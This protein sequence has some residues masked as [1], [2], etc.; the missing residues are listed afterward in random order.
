[1]FLRVDFAKGNTKR[2][3]ILFVMDL[4]AH[5]SN[6]LFFFQEGV[7]SPSVCSPSKQVARSHSPPH[8]AHPPFATPSLTVEIQRHGEKAGS[9]GL[10][11]NGR[12]V[13]RHDVPILAPPIKRGNLFGASPKNTMQIAR[14]S[15]SVHT[16][17]VAR[18]CGWLKNARCGSWQ[19]AARRYTP[20]IPGSAERQ[21]AAEIW[22]AR[23]VTITSPYSGTDWAVCTMAKIC[24]S[25]SLAWALGRKLSRVLSAGLHRH[26][27][28][29]H[30][31]TSH[32]T[33][34][35]FT[36]VTRRWSLCQKK[37]LE[38]PLPLV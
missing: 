30:S 19:L 10:P 4:V 5:P 26:T 2:R 12:D 17:T 6:I 16:R 11:L 3:A 21:F 18:G 35:Q 27:G 36:C 8:S 31:A 34:I 14:V 37:K 38:L 32:S 13:G 20:H 7:C 22:I 1:M 23:C 33:Q 24:W 29:L 15:S 28:P 9:L 25:S